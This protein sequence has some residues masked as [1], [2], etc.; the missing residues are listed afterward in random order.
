M[1]APEFTTQSAAEKASESTTASATQF[2]TEPAPQPAPESSSAS[3][4]V[5]NAATAAP[6]ETQAAAR[7][8]VAEPTEAAVPE[9]ESAA[10]S[11]PAAVEIDL[12]EGTAH[13]V[14]VAVSGNNLVVT[15]DGVIT[16]RPLAEISSLTVTGGNGRRHLLDRRVR[17]GARLP[18]S[19][20][21]RRHSGAG[22]D[23][24][25][26]RSLRSLDHVVQRNHVADVVGRGVRVDGDSGRRAR[27]SDRGVVR[28]REPDGDARRRQHDPGC[29]ERAQA[30]HRRRQPAR[31]APDL[32]V[33]RP[34][35]RSDPVRRTRWG[36]LHPRPT[37]R[38]HLVRHCTKRRHGGRGRLRER[39][40]ARR[41]CRHRRHLHRSGER[42]D[43]ER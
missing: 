6:T 9:A 25:G 28:R 38:H 23:G 2:S 26:C 5:T 40:G 29:V 39:R 19:L 30:D 3:T 18:G 17:C 15:V 24:D 35:R 32:D 42:I 1:A 36:R 7:A 14:T 37:E 20:Q 11:S 27:S 4:P 31:R 21:Q 43:L 12:S 13:T 22:R 33:T 34:G 10:D 16:S 8:P 41:S